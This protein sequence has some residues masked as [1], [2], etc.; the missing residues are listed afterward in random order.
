M[1]QVKKLAK[2]KR[3]EFLYGL[4]DEYA[5]D[6]MISKR[7]SVLELL[8]HEEVREIYRHI[9]LKIKVVTFAQLDEVWVQS[10]EGEK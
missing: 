6:N 10:E 1:N 7:Q 2:E 8:S 9:R 3:V 4:A 5:S